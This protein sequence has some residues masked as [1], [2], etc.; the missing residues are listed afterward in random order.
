M[1]VFDLEEQ[2]ALVSYAKYNGNEKAFVRSPIFIDLKKLW[3]D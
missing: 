3:A 1:V 2:Q